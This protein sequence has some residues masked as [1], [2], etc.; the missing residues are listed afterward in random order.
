[1][2]G[3]FYSSLKEAAVEILGRKEA[4]HIFDGTSAFS[5]SQISKTA[6]ASP[7]ALT[8]ISDAFSIKYQLNTARGLLM[9]IGDASFIKLRRK[10]DQVNKLGNIE[11]RLRPFEKKFQS[12]LHSFSTFLSGLLNRPIDIED[13]EDDCFCINISE[14]PGSASAGGMELYY[15]AGL[16]RAFAM[17]L[18]SRREYSVAV[19][20][21]ESNQ[22]SGRVCLHV[23]PIQ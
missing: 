14:V 2:H 12:A 7:P 3:L 6:S 8:E 1:M 16:L 22:S 17:W 13:C 21:E 20:P 11:S 18:D 5:L 4:Q 23:R 10:F 15:F 19:L 9:R